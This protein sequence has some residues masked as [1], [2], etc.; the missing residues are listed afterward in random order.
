MYLNMM[1]HY[2]I[3][4]YSSNCQQFNYFLP[5][6]LANCHLI[7][8]KRCVHRMN[9]IHH[10]FSL[11]SLI[12]SPR[13]ILNSKIRIGAI[14]ILIHCNTR[15]NQCYNEENNVLTESKERRFSRQSISESSI[16]ISLILI[17]TGNIDNT[18][19]SNNVA[20]FG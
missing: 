7:I 12:F 2:C 14:I 9:I 1:M 19:Q 6:L 17:R 10:A 11:A 4:C 18:S 3:N 5:F 13:D 16:L 8:I 15:L 20:A